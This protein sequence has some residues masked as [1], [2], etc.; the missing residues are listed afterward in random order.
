[1]ENSAMMVVGGAAGY[2]VMELIVQY[3]F[4]RVTRDDLMTVKSCK[5]RH[6]DDGTTIKQL[7]AEITSIKRVL[8]ILA[9]KQGIPPEQLSELVR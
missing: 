3:L 5:E 6:S 2:K 8:L 1:M 9:S 7:T 4:K